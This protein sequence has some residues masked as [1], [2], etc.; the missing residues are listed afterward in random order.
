LGE[1]RWKLR[2]EFRLV[3]GN[4]GLRRACDGHDKRDSDKMFHCV[5]FV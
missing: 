5:S 1:N 2:R 4:S 3:G